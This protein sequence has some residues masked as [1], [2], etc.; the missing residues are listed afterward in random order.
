MLIICGISG[1][2][3]FILL[4][5]A[6]TVPQM[7]VQ[8]FFYGFFLTPEMA[9]YAYIFAKVDKTYYQEVTAFTKAA[10]LLGKLFAGITSQLTVSFHLLDYHQL[11]YVTL[12]G[13]NSF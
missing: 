13:T 9:H 5:V 7:Q 6:K 3:T 11:N 1:I 12:G 4:I 8:Q 10:T 2:I